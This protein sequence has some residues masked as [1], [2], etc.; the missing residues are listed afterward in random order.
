MPLD[1]HQLVVQTMK[2]A[3][4]I[5]TTGAN[6]EEKRI[7]AYEWARA[8]EKAISQAVQNRKT[9]AQFSVHGTTE[10]TDAPLLKEMDERDLNATYTPQSQPSSL[11]QAPSYSQ[12]VPSSQKPTLTQ[13]TV[14][15]PT[16]SQPTISPPT[17]SQPP[18]IDANSQ[19]PLS[20]NQVP[21]GAPPKKKGITLKGL[22]ERFTFT[23]R[24][25]VTIK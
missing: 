7:A 11:S 1:T 23:S 10:S 16:L 6:D 14:S 20:K 15:P 25:Y 13:L 17:H 9:S 21:F 5:S 22:F 3:L 2:R 4:N 19:L 18:T 12:Q 24:G 8:L